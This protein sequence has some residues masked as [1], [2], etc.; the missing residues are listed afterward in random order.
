M[1]TIK[2]ESKSILSKLLASENIHVVHDSQA[3][4]ASFDVQKRVL[5]LPVFKDMSNEVYDMFVG[6]EVS[7]AL[8][9]PF[10][11]EDA[12]SL[13]ENGCLS[14]AFI[15]ANGDRNMVHIAHQ[16][17]NVVEDARIERLIK[18]KFSGLRRDFY[19]GYGELHARDFFGIGND[20]VEEMSFIDRINLF[21]KIG[22][23][24]N[25]PFSDEEMV[26]VNMVENTRTFDDV[27]EVTKKIWE[28]AKEK[29]EGNP[30]SGSDIDFSYDPDGDEGSG[31]MTEAI[32]DIRTDGK[33]GSSGGDASSAPSAPKTQKNFDDAMK[34]NLVEEENLPA[35]REPRYYALPTAK[36]DNI[37]VDFKVM[38]DEFDA[39]A[40]M[41]PQIYL[42]MEQN[43]K[44]F[45]NDSKRVVNILAQEFL[46]KK[47]AK[48]HQRSSVNRTGLI[49][50]VRMMNYKFSDDIFRRMKIV[51]KG[52][53]HGMVFFLDMSGS[54][55]CVYDDTIKQLIQL[56]LFCDR[57]NIPYEVFGFTTRIDVQGN[58]NGLYDKMQDSF[59]WKTPNVPSV[60]DVNTM[61]A[62]NL[63][64][65]FSSRMKKKE[66]V[67]MIRNMMA[68]GTYYSNSQFRCGIPSRMYLSS[69]PL[70]EAIVTAMDF[71]P[72][73]KAKNN[74]DI[75]NTIFLTDGEPTGYN[76]NSS[77]LSIFYKNG[78]TFKYDSRFS[79]ESNMIS[80][81]RSLTGMKAISFF[82]NDS[83]NSLSQFAC[84]I[85][86][87][88]CELTYNES[89]EEMAK[90]TTSYLKEGWTTSFSYGH[91]YNEK[92]IL[93]G[94]NSVEYVDIEQAIGSRK[95]NAAICNNFIKALNKNMVSRVMLNRFVDL[96]AS[97]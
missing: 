46:A 63:V 90:K 75:V 1:T 32:G 15:V 57:V 81:F 51:K 43:A 28:Y 48:D 79:L 94:N 36:I 34:N 91:K 39:Q 16:Y 70:C 68:V 52:K 96:I 35:W 17:M 78:Y 71:V 58:E 2:K 12:K 65:I 3:K 30:Q 20:K 42:D 97:E 73:F 80:I 19:V 66:L 85:N 49:D 26:F 87:G 13:K 83:K 60:Y 45:I 9:T 74:L 59:Y 93:R 25:V 27:V 53:S 11:E 84:D 23:I 61:Q 44:S 77:D 62:Y 31:N 47:A 4:T 14:A 89:S 86:K 40:K 76:F 92:F 67:T 6:H 24:I 41:Y 54:M 5:R 18:N 72:M 22:S 29:N 55:S 38:I 64:N 50:S 69:T 82:V 10:T 7:H 21:F 8:Y 95:T 37:I 56:V 88:G 33:T